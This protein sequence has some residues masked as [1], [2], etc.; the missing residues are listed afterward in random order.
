MIT[1][2]HGGLIA[3]MEAHMEYLRTIMKREL[4]ITKR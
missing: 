1:D 4:H 2:M 3:K